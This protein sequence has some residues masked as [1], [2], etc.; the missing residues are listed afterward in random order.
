MGELDERRR[1]ATTRLQSTPEDSLLVL[2][3]KRADPTLV[4]DLKQEG[5]TLPVALTRAAWDLCVAL[6]PAAER[7]GNDEP[8]RLWD[9]IWM[10]RWAIGRSRGSGG[11]ETCFEVLCTTDNVRPSRVTL[12]SVVGP[13]MTDSR[14]SQSSSPTSLCATRRRRNR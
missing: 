4:I 12:R 10:M 14:S 2:K 13:E 5:F 11:S 3:P 1:C 9:V 7:A 6:S 8:G